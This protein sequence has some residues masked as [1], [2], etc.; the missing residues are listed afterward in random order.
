MARATSD[1]DS[2]NRT[3]SDTQES[4]EQAEEENGLWWKGY[5]MSGF[6][7]NVF[8]G[9]IFFLFKFV[10]FLFLFWPSLIPHREESF[11]AVH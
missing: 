5:R 11:P 6:I 2:D 7:Y 3:E 9:V 8:I 4:R 1:N 10:I